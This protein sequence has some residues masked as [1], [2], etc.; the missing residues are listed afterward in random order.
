MSIAL[1][2]SQ[3]DTLLLYKLDAEL[4]DDRFRIVREAGRSCPNAAHPAE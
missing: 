2:G 4:R 3:H 1:P